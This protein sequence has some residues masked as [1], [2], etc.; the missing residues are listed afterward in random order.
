[1]HILFCAVG[2]SKYTKVSLCENA[3]E[4]WE[5]L[6]VTHEGTSRVKETKIGMLTHEYEL[7]I[8]QPVETISDMYN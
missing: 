7:F 2:A 3:K 6:Q 1:M 8:M 4:I 5:K